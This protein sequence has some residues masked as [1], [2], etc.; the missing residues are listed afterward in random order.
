M[1]AG[2]TQK[3]VADEIDVSFQQLQKYENG[4]NRIPVEQLLA[5]AH[6]LKV[7]VLRPLSLPERDADLL[8]MTE[9]FQANGFH[10]LLESWAE[11]KDQAMCTAILN[12]VKRAAALSR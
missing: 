10:T 12:V 6:Y 2:K 1:A 3:Q 9:R 11:I 5:M 8:S 7:P 4:T